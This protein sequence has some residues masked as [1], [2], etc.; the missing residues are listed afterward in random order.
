MKRD[1]TMAARQGLLLCDGGIGT[2]LMALG[3]P[4]G[5]APE[6]WNLE[7][8]DRV[9]HVHQTYIA[10]G[11]RVLTTNTF[12][13]SP[14]KLKSAKIDADPGLINRRAAEIACQVAGENAW[15][16][17]SI[18]PTGAMLMMGDL[19][20]EA[21]YEGFLLQAQNLLL[22]GADCVIVETMSDLQEALVAVRAAKQAGDK[23]LLAS[24]T[25]TAGQRGYRTMMGVDIPT[26][27]R[28]LTAAGADVLGCNC[29]S[30]ID[31]AIHIIRELRTL[32]SLPLLAEPNAGLPQYVDGQ[33]LFRESPEI[34]AAKIPALLAAGAQ[35]IGGCCGTTPAH[36]AAFAEQLKGLPPC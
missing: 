1:I 17:G 5:E 22:G 28:E 10:A 30:G 34:M 15:V 29:G 8:P 24:M 6:K 36:I 3:L 7:Y 31:D 9:A 4:A 21:M 13:G 11:A 12:G 18:G 32:T 14:Y 2:Q 35:L 23:P 33:T 16:A 27:V 26:A 25:F 20:E 19:S